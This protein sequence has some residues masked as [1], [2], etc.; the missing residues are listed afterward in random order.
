MSYDISSSIQPLIHVQ[1]LCHLT[2]RIEKIMH[3]NIHGGTIQ[4]TPVADS[5]GHCENHRLQLASE[6]AI[7]LQE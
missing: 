6:P 2:L 4:R 1:L 5:F 3:E 7:F